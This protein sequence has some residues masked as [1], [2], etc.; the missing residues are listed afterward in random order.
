[1]SCYF[2]SRGLI[3]RG[4]QGRERGKV[5]LLFWSD[6]LLAQRKSLSPTFSDAPSKPTHPRRLGGQTFS[7]GEYLSLGRV[8][9][10]EIRGDHDRLSPYSNFVSDLPPSTGEEGMVY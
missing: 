9:L 3:T 1:M 8:L 6:S 2:F 5:D 4:L 7:L 10:F